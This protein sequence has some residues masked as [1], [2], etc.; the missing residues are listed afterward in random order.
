LFIYVDDSGDPGFKL[1]RGSSRY[2]AIAAIFFKNEDDM[3]QTDAKID[4]IRTELKLTKR[5]EFKYRK[6]KQEMKEVFMERIGSM[7]FDIGITVVDKEKI[8]NQK[9]VKNPSSFYN[10]AILNTLESWL[11]AKNVYIFI[12]GEAGRGY[13]RDVKT[14]FRKN[15]PRGFIKK[16]VYVDSSENNLIQ[17]ADMVAGAS[18]DTIENDTGL[19]RKIW[20]HVRRYSSEK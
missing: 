20:K 1:S 19:L 13:R 3:K 4:Q 10:S 8:T 2:F 7:N 11:D 14:F 16:V 5:H 17:L 9:I 6:L 15:L 12:D 18:I